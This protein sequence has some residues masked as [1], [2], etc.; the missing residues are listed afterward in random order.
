VSQSPIISRDITSFFIL[1]TTTT[2]TT[3]KTTTAAAEFY[4]DKIFA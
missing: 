4:L 1:T 3:T 2:T